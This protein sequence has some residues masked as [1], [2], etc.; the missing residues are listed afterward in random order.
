MRDRL[1]AAAG[2]AILVAALGTAPAGMAVARAGPDAL[3]VEGMLSDGRSFS[4]TIAEAALWTDAAGQLQMAG[5]L[6]GEA[7]TPTG[8]VSH[9]PGHAFVAPA[10]VAQ[11]DGA[12]CDGLRLDLG[13]IPIDERGLLLL[14][15]VSVSVQRAAEH[16]VP[17][18]HSLLATLSCEE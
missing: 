9:T 15:P 5:V 14:G 1:V 12:A 7:R 3:P 13:L 18:A 2:A 4:G 17:G 16:A 10:L 6:S 8:L 11:A